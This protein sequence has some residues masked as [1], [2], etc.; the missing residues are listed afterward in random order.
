MQASSAACCKG[1]GGLAPEPE[2]EPPALAAR[3]AALAAAHFF[4]SS[5]PFF[6]SSEPRARPYAV[7]ASIAACWIAVGGLGAFPAAVSRSRTHFY[8]AV[9]SFASPFARH[10]SCAAF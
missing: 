2:P 3:A 9:G 1:V 4:Q 8:S 7:H 10:A 5:E 6:Q